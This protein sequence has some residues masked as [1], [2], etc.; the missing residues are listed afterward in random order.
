MTA[1]VSWK[2]R[3][4]NIQD[5][6]VGAKKSRVESSWRCLIYISSYGL[7]KILSSVFHKRKILYS[8]P[9]FLS[10]GGIQCIASSHDFLL[11]ILMNLLLHLMGRTWSS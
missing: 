1:F 7:Y 2:G 5:K 3:F 8:T 9:P 10:Q 4:H 11:M 6:Y